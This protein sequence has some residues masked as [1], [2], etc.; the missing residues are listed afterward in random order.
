[1]GVDSIDFGF[2]GST[3]DEVLAGMRKFRVEVLPL[4]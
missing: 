2:G 3:A 4:V 1:M